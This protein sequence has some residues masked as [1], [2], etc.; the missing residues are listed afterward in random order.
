LSGVLSIFFLPALFVFLAMVAAWLIL[1]FVSV[2]WVER[3]PRV[4]GLAAIG[5]MSTH[6]VYGAAFMRGLTIRHL[7]R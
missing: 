6:L 1:G 4:A 5:I 3:D 7:D 2:M